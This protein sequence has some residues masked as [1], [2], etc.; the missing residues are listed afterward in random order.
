VEWLLLDGRTG[1]ACG[2]VD[3]N[4]QRAEVHPKVRNRHG[5]GAR[6]ATFAHYAPTSSPSLIP[7]L[8]DLPA[9]AAGAGRPQVTCIT[10]SVSKRE[11]R[12]A[13]AKTTFIKALCRG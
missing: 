10:S 3:T 9:A 8:A 2:P 4:A 7:S 6:Q 5:L 13:P 12:W 11:A 1:R